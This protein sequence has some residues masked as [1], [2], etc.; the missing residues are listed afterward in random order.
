MKLRKKEIF[1][2]LNKDGR[3]QST[4]SSTRSIRGYTDVKCK[5][6]MLRKRLK[7]GLMSKKLK[8]CEFYFD[9]SCLKLYLE[10]NSDQ[11]RSQKA[12]KTSN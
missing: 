2:C 6:A 12:P 1:Q 8:R 4:S 5:F 7:V 3:G 11:K 9:Y 10:S